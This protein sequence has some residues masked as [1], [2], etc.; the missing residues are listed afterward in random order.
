MTRILAALDDSAVTA[1]VIAVAQWLAEQFDL[2]V[3]ALHVSENGS[4][5]IA[6]QSADAAG[7]GFE[8][9]EGDPVHVIRQA[10]DDPD[11]RAVVLGARG[12]PASRMPAGHVTLDV[13]R[14]ATKPVVVVP[15]D[16]RVPST[17][18]PIRLLAPV[19]TA[20]PSADAVR[21]LLDELQTPDLELVLLHVVDAQHLPMFA[22]HEPHEEEAWREE[23][24]RRTTPQHAASARVERRV[25]QPAPTILTAERDIDPD[26]VVLAWAG[27]L[28]RGRAAVIK[29]LLAEATTP[30]V[31]LPRADNPGRDHEAERVRTP[32]AD[33]DVSDTSRTGLASRG[34]SHQS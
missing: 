24:A 5:T 21:R 23:F 11:V 3:V 15:P 9:R 33:P 7:V 27:H 22:N 19:N 17:N 20:R 8:L 30:L 26:L 14:R 28:E 6:R 25:G 32:R 18:G 1:P 34:S 16:A 12:L 29:R 2:E 31:L 10:A 13:I 4:G